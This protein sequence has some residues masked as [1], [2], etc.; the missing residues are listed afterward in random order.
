MCGL[1]TLIKALSA[2]GSGAITNSEIVEGGC[3]T[4]MSGSLGERLNALPQHRRCGHPSLAPLA[5]IFTAGGLPLNLPCALLVCAVADCALIDL[6]FSACR[7]HCRVRIAVWP[8]RE[9]KR[10]CE[11]KEKNSWMI[12][13]IGLD[14]FQTAAL[15]FLFFLPRSFTGCCHLITWWRSHLQRWKLLKLDDVL[16]C[17]SAQRHR[18]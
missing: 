15:F 8:W 11:A 6:H 17:K 4:L 9:R 2:S 7:Y 10:T 5:L 18:H 1:Q 12:C 16:L 14:L 13:M 3:L